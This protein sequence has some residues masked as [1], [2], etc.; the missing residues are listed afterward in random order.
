MIYIYSADLYSPHN[1]YAIKFIPWLGSLATGYFI[2]R[3]EN[4]LTVFVDKKYCKRIT[5]MEFLLG[6]L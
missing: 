3:Q 6:K 5:E 4:G 1:Y 2:F